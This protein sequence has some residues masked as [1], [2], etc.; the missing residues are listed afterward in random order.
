VCP[1]VHTNSI[2]THTSHTYSLSHPP[3]G[4]NTHTH[5]HTHT[6]THTHTHTNKH[7]HTFWVEDRFEV[8]GGRENA[9]ATRAVGGGHPV[10]GPDLL[11]VVAA[12]Y[13]VQ[14]V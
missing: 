5:T 9:S 13:V 12:A 8:G 3:S 14:C 1:S 11:L 6:Y 10:V 7:T 2:Y 4:L